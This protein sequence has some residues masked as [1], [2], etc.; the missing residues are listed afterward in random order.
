[1]LMGTWQER[2]VMCSLC[3]FV[4]CIRVLAMFPICYVRDYVLQIMLLLYVIGA[5][6]EI[7]VVDWCAMAYCY[8]V[9]SCVCCC[10]SV[11]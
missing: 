5:W 8:Q 7:V 10:Y 9:C 2:V 3:V 6:Q 1:M 4:C 11:L